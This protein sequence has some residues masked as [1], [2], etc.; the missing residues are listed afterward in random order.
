MA[1][2]MSRRLGWIDDSIVERVHRILQEA[3]LP[4]HPPEVMTVEKFKSVMAVST[5]NH[6]PSLSIAPC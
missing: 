5:S 6:K 4:T 2:D 3:K 1:V